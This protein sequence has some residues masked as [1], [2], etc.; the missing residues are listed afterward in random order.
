[1]KSEL[2]SM[3]RAGGG[4]GTEKGIDADRFYPCCAQKS[5]W[6]SMAFVVWRH[7]FCRA[8]EQAKKKRL[9]IELMGA[10]VKRAMYSVLC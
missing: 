9:A 7:L 8:S 6:C 2:F 5:L 10:L 3:Q 4:D 1:M